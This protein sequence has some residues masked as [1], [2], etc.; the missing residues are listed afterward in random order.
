VLLGPCC[1][2]S[3]FT[4]RELVS[5]CVQLGFSKLAADSPL[6]LRSQG[7]SAE[8]ELVSSQWEA[9]RTCPDR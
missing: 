3:T 6:L 2:H 4:K 5:V 8:L 1:L 7:T 9:V